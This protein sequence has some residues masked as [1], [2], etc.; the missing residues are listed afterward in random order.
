MRMGRFV[1]VADEPG[2]PRIDGKHF[3]KDFNNKEEARLFAYGAELHGYKGVE[4]VDMSPSWT[5]LPEPP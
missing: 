2:E 5:P 4:I 3:L 1:I